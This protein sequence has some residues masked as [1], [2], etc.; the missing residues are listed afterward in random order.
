MG[1]DRR[2]QAC[3]RGIPH[4]E[5][6]VECLPGCSSIVEFAEDA[7]PLLWHWSPRSNRA[8]I[9]ADGL[10]PGNLANDG[11]WNPPHICL[12]ESPD[13]ALAL[14]HGK[15]PLD[16]WVV[17]RDNCMDLVRVEQEWRTTQPVHAHRADTAAMEGT[18]L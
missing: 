16:L 18:L 13:R 2:E 6:Q 1:E 10:T 5:C 9:E 7:P 8:S 17:H 3:Q 4:S 12:A 11:D 15:P 14:C